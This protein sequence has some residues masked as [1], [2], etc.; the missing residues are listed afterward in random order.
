MYEDLAA[1]AG[2]RP[3]S[4]ILEI[5]CGTGQATVEL[6]RRGYRVVAV[7]LGAEMASVARRNLAQ[8]PDVEVIVAAFEEWPL[9]EERFDAVFCATAFHW[10]DP[11][12]ATVKPVRALRSGGTVAIVDTHHILG[13]TVEFFA[14]SQR[15]YERFDPATPPDL[16]LAPA[17]AIPAR[18]GGTT[19]RYEWDQ[20]YTTAEYLDVLLTY[21]GH[22]AL[23]EAN[24]DGLLDCV[25]RLIDTR[26]GGRVVKRYLTELT[27]T[28]K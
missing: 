2:L 17:S 18:A 3:G 11:E 4:R 16:R 14:D 10:L 5:G 9:P 7:E 13:G 23:P 15:C 21:S 20:P 25:T 26:Y 28:R 22:R 6:A 12:V 24:R 19:R 27:C 1:A 8:F